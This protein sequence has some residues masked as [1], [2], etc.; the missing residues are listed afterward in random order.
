VA[1]L[2]P[3]CEEV[4][5][6]DPCG[7]EIQRHDGACWAFDISEA[8]DLIEAG[9]HMKVTVHDHVIVGASGRTSMKALGLI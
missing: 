7:H 2:A 3:A 1:M 5:A 8:R 9:R 4:S 6:A